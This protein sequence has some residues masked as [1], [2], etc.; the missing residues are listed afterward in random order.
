MSLTY[1]IHGEGASE[2]LSLV[3]GLSRALEGHG[4]RPAQG[5]E[6]PNLVLNLTS[7]ENPKPYRRK[8]QATFVLSILAVKEI[9]EAAVQAM[10]PY[11]VRTLS[12]M[13]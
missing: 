1:A 7:T 12:N 13:L 10:Y 11:L 6:A 2:V 8:S 3:R 4:Y 9:P 5:D